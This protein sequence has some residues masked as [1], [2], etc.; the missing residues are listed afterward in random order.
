MLVYLCYLCYRLCSAVKTTSPTALAV[1]A[2]GEEQAK[3]EALSSRLIELGEDVDMILAEIA[4]AADEEE[5]TA[6]GAAEADAEL[7]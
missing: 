3:V 2:A 7:L 1:P 5:P 4:A 6:D